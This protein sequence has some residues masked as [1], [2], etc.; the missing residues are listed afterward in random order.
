MHRYYKN[1]IILTDFNCGIANA[2]IE[3]KFKNIFRYVAGQLEES[4]RL[5]ADLP[6]SDWAQKTKPEEPPYVVNIHNI[7]FGNV[8]YAA[9]ALYSC[10]RSLGKGMWP[11]IFIHVTDPGVGKGNDRSLLIT[12]EDNVFIGPNNGSLGLMVQFFRERRVPY[13]LFP[14]DQQLIEKMEQI[15]TASPSYTM[16]MTFHG[17]DLMAVVAGMVAGGM[18]PNHVELDTTEPFISMVNSFAAYNSALPLQIG[19]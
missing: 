17:R 5:P 13:S 14:L 7:P 19:E 1:I 18:Q 11:N 6:W 3:L 8:D 16:P 12:D 4:E 9:Y 10:Y 2:Q 15:R